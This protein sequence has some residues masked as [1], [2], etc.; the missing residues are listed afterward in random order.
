M[1]LI[2]AYKENEVPI[3]LG[4]VLTTN[5]FKSEFHCK[6][7][8]KISSNFVIAWTGMK[9]YAMDVLKSLM[10]QFQDKL[11]TMNEVEKFLL[12]FDI[13]SF[14]EDE[15]LTLIGWVIDDKTYCFEWF[16]NLNKYEYKE[17]YYLENERGFFAG[18]GSKF[19]EGLLQ[20]SEE[21][22]YESST[23]N[24]ELQALG[25]VLKEVCALTNAEYL[26]VDK[27]WRQGFGF[28]YEIL[29]YNGK[30][31]VYVDDILYFT[32]DIYT[33]EDWTLSQYTVCP[34]F[35]RYKTFG[36]ISL[37]QVQ[38]NLDSFNDIH[39]YYVGKGFGND[40][41][42]YL[43]IQ[44]S[45]RGKQMILSN[46]ANCYCLTIRIINGKKAIPFFLTVFGK[47]NDLIKLDQKGNSTIFGFSP[48]FHKLIQSY[49]DNNKY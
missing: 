29:F 16:S 33:T 8:I 45:I 31:F 25:K 26:A 9:S 46:K 19:F 47:K 6:K 41:E 3:L 30:S 40:V 21:S 23:S 24:Q 43:M 15:N 11:V 10:Q 1:T 5:A 13:S 37:F 20:E 28:G 35:Y 44:N 4:D 32:L 48:S 2:A 38:K 18:S 42:N 7:I 39:Q 49:I 34:Y 12:N 27:S 36:N 17:I 14:L 22:T